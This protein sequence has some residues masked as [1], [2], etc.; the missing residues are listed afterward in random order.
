MAIIQHRRGTTADWERNKD[1][2]LERGEI[3]IQFCDDSSVIL[4]VGDGL[5]TYEHLKDLTIPGYATEDAV[6]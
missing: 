4:K 6:N 5:T 3:G 2:V 1:I